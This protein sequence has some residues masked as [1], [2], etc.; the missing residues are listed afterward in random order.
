MH[1]K[2]F[3]CDEE[4]F[5]ICVK[6][7]F[8]GHAMSNLDTTYH[9]CTRAKT[10]NIISWITW[11]IHVLYQAELFPFVPVPSPHTNVCKYLLSSLYECCCSH[12]FGSTGPH[13]PTTPCTHHRT[14]IT[15]PST[16]TLTHPHQARNT[17]ST[18]YRKTYIHD[19]S[20]LHKA[21]IRI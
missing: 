4:C 2:S 5:I 11:V 19:T 12:H 10:F 14:Q 3:Y 8:V 9:S 6:L 20:I 16:H 1:Y 13:L 17:R 15:R 18:E 7:P 21:E